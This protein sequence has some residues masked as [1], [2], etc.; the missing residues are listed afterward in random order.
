MPDLSEALY[1][2]DVLTLVVVTVVGLGAGLMVD[3]YAGAGWQAAMY[4]LVGL[5]FLGFALAS[6]AL[7]GIET[8]PRWIGVIVLYAAFT[9]GL[10]AGLRVQ[11]RRRT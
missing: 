8:W 6:R 2:V 9:A 1:V 10:W 3:R 5:A 7:Q 4:G 11:E